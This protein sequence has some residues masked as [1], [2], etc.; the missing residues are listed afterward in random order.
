M[1]RVMRYPGSVKDHRRPFGRWINTVAAS[2]HELNVELRLALYTG[3]YNIS[4]D[5]VFYGGPY[6]DLTVHTL[7]QNLRTT[8]KPTMP[9][10]VF[11]NMATD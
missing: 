1:A 11:M 10:K 8:P 2:Y 3:G 6:V 9:M 5:D 4:L 7:A